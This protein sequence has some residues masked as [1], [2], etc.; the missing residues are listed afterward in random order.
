M[1]D[2]KASTPGI[3]FTVD[4][5]LFLS[6]FQNKCRVPKFNCFPIYTLGH[7]NTLFS[8]NRDLSL[9]TCDSHNH[10]QLILLL[11]FEQPNNKCT[12][13]SI[14]LSRSEE[15]FACTPTHTIRTILFPLV[16]VGKIRFSNNQLQ[17]LRFLC[18]H[19]LCYPTHR[20][21][22]HVVHSFFLGQFS[23]RFSSLAKLDLVELYRSINS[24]L[25]KM[26]FT[27]F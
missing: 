26:L 23:G 14:F 16:E 15:L 24:V 25:S 13:C 4:C 21:S 11:C 3:P 2:P 7:L 6:K 20:C 12:L 9:P 1:P 18:N 8:L 27:H 19:F 5:L 10:F 22:L 17:Q